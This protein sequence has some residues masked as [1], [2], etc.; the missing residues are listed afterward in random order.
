MSV[1]RL[2]Q[3]LGRRWG[4]APALIE[5]Q[6]ARTVSFAQLADA[7]FGFARTLAA[8]GL[9][10]GDRFALIGDNEIEYLIAD[11]GGMCG[12]FVRAPLDP[13]LSM[14]ELRAQVIDAEATILVATAEHRTA[15]ENVA[16]GLAIRVL[17]IERLDPSHFSSQCEL[18]PDGGDVAAGALASLNYTGGSSGAP[19]AVMLSHANLR[20]ILQNV[21]M[22]RG[23]GPGD[24]MVNMRPLWPIAAVIVLAHLS[25]GGTV[26]LGGRFEPQRL[27]SLLA[28][29]RAAATTLVPTHLV[30]IVRDC[31]AEQ[32]RSLTALRSI[33]IG[34][35]AVPLDVFEQALAAFGPK[36]GILYGLTEASWSCYQPPAM[37]DVAA[38]QRPARMGSVGRPVFGCDIKIADGD[39]EVS[40]GEV[41]EI[42]IRGANVMQGYWKRPDLTAE[43]LRVG[44]FHTGD[45]G[46]IDVDG[47]LSV[48]GRLKNV[49]RSGG[50]SVDPAEVEKVLA[51]APG[52]AEVAVL[53][54]PD[55]E[56]GE[57]VV[58]AV[59]PVAGVMLDT[60]TLSSHCA[61][62]LSANKRPKQ[63]VFVTELPRSH[64]GKV[65]LGRLKADLIE[66]L[67]RT[68]NG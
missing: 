22:V 14:D 68:A 9:R 64:Y 8:R 59:V 56:W 55:T 58:A 45:L 36:I 65:Q 47:V 25:A 20:A 37:L 18:L 48:V 60:R 6:S 49:I 41:G 11:Y 34:A 21:A 43:V 29:Y 17:P 10:P 66:L 32:L 4:D 15:A 67:G 3:Q 7:S 26:V 16:A 12:G 1:A 33:N 40:S 53:G 28:K 42:L 30:R 27:V 5:D 38:E 51:R 52:V 2:I 23:M 44:W 46:R 31:P 57:I 63:I 35:A 62:E 24:T 54:L 19:K 13:S 50:K 39:T 61:A